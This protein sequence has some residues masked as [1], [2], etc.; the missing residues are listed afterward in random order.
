MHRALKELCVDSGAAAIL[1]E[2]GG[3]VR[4]LD[5]AEVKLDGAAA[6]EVAKCNQ[7]VTINAGPHAPVFAQ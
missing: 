4:Y 1:D 5:P 7:P 2:D 6:K 3:I